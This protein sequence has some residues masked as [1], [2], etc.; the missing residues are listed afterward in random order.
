MLKEP[1]RYEA[2]G[3]LSI[4]T[5][6]GEGKNYDP[7]RLSS[8]FVVEKA[9]APGETIKLEVETNKYAIEGEYQITWHINL[10]DIPGEKVFEYTFTTS[11]IGKNFR[12]GCEIVSLN[13]EWH[14]YKKYDH[15]LDVL[16]N[17]VP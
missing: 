15:Q 12:I 3:F 2:P 11:D 17:V 9:Y 13:K 6:T 10:K 8:A 14:R 5:E 1:I 16:V 4:K 7:D